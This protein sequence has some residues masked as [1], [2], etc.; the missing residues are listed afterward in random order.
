MA[1]AGL[2]AALGALLAVA[3]LSQRLQRHPGGR[4]LRVVETSRLGSQGVLAV[5]RAGERCF[6]VAATASTVASV[7][8][9]DAREWA[10]DLAPPDLAS[11]SK[12][13]LL[14]A[15]RRAL[16]GGG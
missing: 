13:G 16:L 9:L 12:E 6:L 7:A 5:V 1:A 2:V 4:R 11:E 15:A 10:A 3:L 8:E 14:F